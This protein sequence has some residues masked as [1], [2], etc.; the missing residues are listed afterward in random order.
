MQTAVA[1][2]APAS[3]TASQGRFACSKLEAFAISSFR[4]V[5]TWHGRSATQYAAEERPAAVEARN[6]ELEEG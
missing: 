3:R 2:Q 5:N 4:F 6:V 1:V